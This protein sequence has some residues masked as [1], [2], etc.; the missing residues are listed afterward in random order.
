MSINS[1]NYKEVREPEHYFVFLT[2]CPRCGSE[3]DIYIEAEHVHAYQA[4]VFS[5]QEGVLQ[6]KTSLIQN[7]FVNL[8]VDEREAM[9]TGI[10][11]PCWD[12]MFP[13]E[14]EPAL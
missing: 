4:G 3:R 2:V 9:M 7:A 14:P 10:C 1:W 6:N 13:P 5:I 11:P 12:N 8:D